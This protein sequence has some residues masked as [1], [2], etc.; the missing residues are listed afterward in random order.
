M[1]LEKNQI[2]ELIKNPK[3]KTKIAQIKKHESALRVFTEELEKEDLEKESYWIELTEEMK[4]KAVNKYDRISQFMRFPLSV[5]QITDS[6]LN[7]FYKIYEGKNRYFNVS[8]NRETDVLDLWMKKHNPQ[9]WVENV[10]RKVF[11]NKPSTFVVV[12]RKKDGE[13]YLLAV[14]SSRV[15]DFYIDEDGDCKYI[16]FVHSVELNDGV[17]KTN[18]SF[19]DE[20]NY[21]VFSKME[22]KEDYVL[23]NEKK[24][25][26]NYCPAR[27]FVSN[28]VS[29]K[30]EIK[31]KTVFGSSISKLKDYVVFDIFEN[32]VDH[33]VPFPVM[34]APFSK[35]SNQKCKNG[36]IKLENAPSG[37]EAWTDCQK[38]SKNKK[39]SFIGPGTV[40]KIPLQASKDKEDG[41]GKFK[42]HF[43]E[44]DK[45]KHIPEK[46]KNLESEIKYKTIGV[47][48]VLEKEAVNEM[49]VKGSFA[50]MESVLLRSKV[51]LDDI[52]KWIVETVGNL[53]YINA[54][55]NVD[56]DFGTEFY[57]LS[58][59]QLQSLFE[60]AKEIGLPREEL[61][62]IYIQL[63][64]T[65]YKGNNEKI[66]RHLML[67]DLDSY[68]F[69]TEKECVEF[70]KD[71]IIDDFEL[72]L[73]INFTRFVSKFEID[74]TDI[75]EF[76]KGL[77]YSNRI[78]IILGELERYNEALIKSK[79]D[80]SKP[81][82]IED[83]VSQEQLDAQANLRGTVGGVQGLIEIQKSI[84]ENTTTRESALTMLEEIYGFSK[85]KSE[86]I[87]GKVINNKNNNNE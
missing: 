84:S 52:Y 45:M 79:S 55:I 28:T 43:P 4:N 6:I 67:M 14:D 44:T 27:L 64:N 54:N 68:S 61:K 78:S 53:Y 48:N 63:I 65:K 30:N 47:S 38:C 80:R 12:D 31:S 22:D 73:K 57:L 5:V 71:S 40:L 20:E 29:S 23:E 49:Q 3:N 1:R 39:S 2:L 51:V 15:L 35:C 76:G 26:L 33:Y 85:E 60:N 36:K 62:S 16:S 50:S 56:A 46:L 7:D 75:T 82:E 10:S 13:P 11:K 69:Y 74:N 59:S 18:I 8:A 34:E 41:S 37:K 24:H 87:L 66:N 21:Y 32:Y 58:E 70:K 81:T 72:S 86:R 19:Y 17:K 25:N 42:M 77:E 83:T 9:S